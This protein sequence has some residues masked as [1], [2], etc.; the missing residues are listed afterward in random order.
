LTRN[1][2][3]KEAK[4]SAREQSKRVN[5]RRKKTQRRRRQ[6]QKT[7]RTGK[8]YLS[9]ETT[10]S[11]AYEEEK[12]RAKDRLNPEEGKEADGSDANRKKRKGDNPNPGQ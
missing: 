4:A 2:R 6:H 3:K 11:R 5:F 1:Q 7:K 8:R 10:L 9:W 12:N